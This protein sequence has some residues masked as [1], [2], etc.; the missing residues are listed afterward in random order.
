MSKKIL[1]KIIL[2]FMALFLVSC[3]KGLPFSELNDA[4][5]QTLMNLGEKLLK[6]VALD[7]EKAKVNS[8]LERFFIESVD[9]EQW[10]KNYCYAE[11]VSLGKKSCQA[12]RS[13]CDGKSYAK[14]TIKKRLR[15]NFALF[16]NELKN[17]KPIDIYK[18]FV[19]HASKDADLAKVKCG[20]D[21]ESIKR[22]S[23]EKYF[24]N[25]LTLASLYSSIYPIISKY[26]KDAI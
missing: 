13:Q 12:A 25:N 19:A 1:I 20:D 8:I 18:A 6:E 26:F 21:D 22:K 16:L 7:S 5:K 24:D 15:D 10:H 11:S 3:A 4:D 2:V 9:Q 23:L 17:Y 14:D